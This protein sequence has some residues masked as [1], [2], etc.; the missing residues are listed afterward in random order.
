MSQYRDF[1]MDY[2]K[3]H[4]KKEYSLMSIEEEV[5]EIELIN[6]EGKDPVYKE[7]YY[8][9]EHLQTPLITPVLANQKNRDEIV[10]FTGRF[11]D[12]HANQLSTSGP[13][14]IF[15]FGEKEVQPLYDMFNVN[16]ELLLNL[17][18]E[19]VKETYF[20]KISKV[21][22]GF[23]EKAPHKILLV[24]ILID[25]IQ[26]GYDDIR[27]CNEYLWA[28]TEYPILYRKSWTTG[29]KED[30]MNYTIEHLGNKFKIKKMK[31]LQELLKYDA[32]KSV[33]NKLDQL[34]QGADNVYCDLT[35]RMRNQ[36][37]NT[38]QNIA[39]AYY[40]NSKE[41]ATQHNNTTMFDDGEIADQEGHASQTTQII[42]RI[43]EKF[44]SKELNSAMLKIA[45]DGAKVDKGNLNG[46]IVSIYADK[47]NQLNKFIENILGLYFVK[48]SGNS[49]IIAGEFLSFGLA[50]YRSIGTSKDPVMQ[51][52][53]QII[54][55]WMNDVVNIR[56]YYNREA[57]C[58][59]Y[60]RAVFNYFIL[61]INYFA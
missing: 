56:E 35:Y 4:R 28:F 29:V 10:D 57:T 19:M 24:A 22:D 46:F 39:D 40:K 48:Y 20:G 60:T 36:F 59:A 37:K 33:E 14:Y 49:E 47:Y 42:E 21:Y 1:M 41:N 12:K 27:T 45:A 53:K 5:E 6:E 13:V 9:R 16:G 15:T 7:N 51:E 23:F 3:E 26:N 18:R 50:L 25:A 31:N 8:L 34:K 17:Y 61:M 52:L 43:C 38:L 58:I 54:N 11:I 32:N 30:V 55:H 2:M 44:A